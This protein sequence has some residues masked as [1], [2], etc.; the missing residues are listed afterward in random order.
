MT[1]HAACRDRAVYQGL[2][3]DLCGPPTKAAEKIVLTCGVITFFT[4]IKLDGGLPLNDRDSAYGGL[5]ARF[6]FG[7]LVN[8]AVLESLIDLR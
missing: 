7:L 1:P 6:Q 5:D 4:G 8:R 2:A 3:V